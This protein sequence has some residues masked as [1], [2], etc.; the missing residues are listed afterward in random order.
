MVCYTKNEPVKCV[1]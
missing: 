1:P